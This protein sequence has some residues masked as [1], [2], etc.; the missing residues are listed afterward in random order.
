MDRIDGLYNSIVDDFRE[1]TGMELE[2]EF[3]SGDLNDEDERRGYWVIQNLYVINPEVDENAI[4]L[5][6]DFDVICGG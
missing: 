5:L 1:K 2:L 6:H 3:P 4:K